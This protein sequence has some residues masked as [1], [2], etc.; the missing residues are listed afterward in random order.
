MATEECECLRGGAGDTV[1]MPTF[2]GNCPYVLSVGATELNRGS[3]NSTPSAHERPLHEVAGVYSRVGRGFPDVAA[4]G[5]R[6][7][8]VSGG[9]W[10]VVGGTSMSAPVWASV[11]TFIYEERIAAGQPT[12]GFVHLILV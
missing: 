10:Y 3:S 2:A 9:K 7:I 5:D 4:V 8:L 1:F 11:L 6:A 12:L